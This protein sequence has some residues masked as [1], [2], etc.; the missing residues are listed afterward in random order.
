MKR[1]SPMF[2]I[3]KAFH[4]AFH[5][6]STWAF[7]V[8]IALMF[9]LMSGSLAWVIEKG[10]KRSIAEQHASDAH[11]PP[12]IGPLKQALDEKTRALSAS[13]QEN[14]RLES[15]LGERGRN[16]KNRLKVAELL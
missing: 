12:E 16:K 2:D 10:Y 3:V 14:E 7:V 11:K 8:P 9:A 13:E 1:G 15:Q 6:E 4:E 5:T